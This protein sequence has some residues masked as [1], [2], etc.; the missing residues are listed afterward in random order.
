LFLGGPAIHWRL[1]VRYTIVLSLAKEQRLPPSGRIRDERGG[2]ARGAVGS[3][4]VTGASA[5]IGRELARVF[6]SRGYDLILAARSRETIAA[7]AKELIATH[8]VDVKSLPV[9]LSVSGAAQSMFDGLEQ[10]GV[11][12]DILVNNAGV[13][14]EG[15]FSSITL[16]DHL[17]LM[18]INVV[19]PTSLT[20]LFLPS[21]LQR[22]S[23]RI[24]NVAS[25]AAFIPV[26]R[27]AAYAA[28]KAYVLS[29][30][31]AL[32][33]ELRGTGVTATALCPG[34]T[35]TSMTR[36]SRI[37][38]AVPAVMFMSAAAVAE[39]GVAACLG[40]ETI[41]VPGVANWALTSGA[42]ILPRRLVRMVS[43][44]MTAG[45]RDRTASS[46]TARGSAIAKAEKERDEG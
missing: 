4:L 25:T 27:L 33:E 12:V 45:G 36:A 18:Q 20:R 9:D 11:S 13:L 42:P 7:L 17:R 40:G 14:F 24:L 39:E 41:C 21:M 8:G 3:V 37:A 31:E 38:K 16:E 23:G 19:A 46:R 1:I 26:P 6:A 15:D 2:K 28:A 30:T 29:L 10:S 32:S 35:D 43:G 22:R 34:F 5:G 44:L